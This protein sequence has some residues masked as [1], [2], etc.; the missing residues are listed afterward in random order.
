[1]ASVE[2]ITAQL[3]RQLEEANRKVRAFVFGGRGGTHTPRCV[4]SRRAAPPLQI[5]EFVRLQNESLGKAAKDHEEVM[6]AMEGACRRH[7]AAAAHTL[8][9]RQR[10]PPPSHVQTRF[11]GW[12]TTR[13]LP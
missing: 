5:D 6:K 11:R 9:Q 8:A 3:E 10:L 4:T 1:M 12:R 7:H 2:E 13:C